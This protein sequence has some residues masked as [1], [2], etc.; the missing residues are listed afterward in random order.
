MTAV[1]RSPGKQGLGALLERDR[2]LREAAELLADIRAER[3]RLLLVEAPPGLGKSTL[4]EHVAAH[5]G[6]AGSRVVSA[7]GREL[8]RG[9]GWG[10]ARSLFE[11]WLFSLPR[12]ERDEV[13]GGPAASARV[14]FDTDA[15]PEERP[16]SDVSFGILHG[17][18]WLA[19]RLTEGGS[20]L[21]VVD[22]AHWVDEPSLRFL[23]Y[24]LGRIGDQPIGLLVAAR[25]GESG[26]GGLL[27]ALAADRST[28]VCELEPLGPEAVAALIRDRVPAA[29]DGFCRRCW[30]L[31]AGNP[32]GVRELVSA[33]A[34]R[35]PAQA[36]LDL[37]AIAERAARS[38]SRSVLRRLGAL[39]QRRSHGRRGGRGVRGRRRA[40]SCC[41]ACRAR[42]VRRPRRGRRA[43]ARRHPRCG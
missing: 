35:A 41:G 26:E 39:S 43:L 25:T 8:E 18:Y 36:A 10:V 11:P 13:L 19:V 2:Q 29:D 20:S 16:A 15:D 17:L 33:L 40:P 14:L 34:E 21:L 27:T 3:G 6:T 12:E 7:A 22:D 9:L 38:L 28:T 32:L 30:E 24:V 4:V 31:T 23:S 5:A 1:G 42:D 37:D